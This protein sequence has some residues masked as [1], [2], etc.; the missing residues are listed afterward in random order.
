MT[1][2]KTAARR[3][4]PSSFPGIEEIQLVPPGA[5]AILVNLSATGLLVES[6]A[7]LGPG[8]DVSVE[9]GGGF[10][11]SSAESRVIRCEVIGITAGGS[12][13][14][15]IGLAFNAR[16]PLPNETGSDEAQPSD[17]VAVAA[18]PPPPAPGAAPP[19]ILRNRW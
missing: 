7:R 12:L 13:R 14:Y 11:P 5:P 9:F 16:I 15:R 4:G 10:T 1:S 18:A 2:V 17:E 8:T 6:E 19:R 3:Y